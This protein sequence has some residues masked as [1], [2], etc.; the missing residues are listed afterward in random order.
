MHASVICSDPDLQSEADELGTQAVREY[1]LLRRGRQASHARRRGTR[2]S[3]VAVNRNAIY[4]IRSSTHSWYLKLPVSDASDMVER[5]RLGACVTRD[6]VIGKTGCLWPSLLCVST[7]PGYILSSAI[8]G[9]YLTTL[10]YRSSWSLVRRGEHEAIR[11]FYRFGRLLARLHTCGPTAGVPPCAS[12]GALEKTRKSFSQL[13]RLDATCA[14]VDK[15]LESFAPDTDQCFLH[16]NLRRENVLFDRGR[17]GL[18][19][20]ET[21]GTGSRYEDLSFVSANLALSRAALVFPWSRIYAAWASLL[22]GYQHECRIDR[23]TLWGYTLLHLATSYAWLLRGKRV[24]IATIPIS[25]KRLSRLI[26]AVVDGR[27]D[28]QFPGLSEARSGE[29]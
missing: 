4:R 28:P 8:P 9:R 17:V 23:T 1:E 3:R 7:D 25:R 6:C 22:D 27:D 10:L 15:W 20:F 18:I 24:T 19:D 13:R 21:C 26:H 12:T 29:F 16:G 2:W 14:L 5:E 11:G